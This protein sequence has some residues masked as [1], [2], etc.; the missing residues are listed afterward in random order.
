M[1]GPTN[2][3]ANRGPSA[4]RA[5]TAILTI[6]NLISSVRILAIPAFVALIVNDDTASAGIVLFAVVAATDWI[7]GAVA[8]RTGQVSQ[9][10]TILDPVADRLA[11]AAGLV[12]LVVAGAVPLWV[13]LVVVVRDAVVLLVGALALGLRGIRVEVRSLGKIATFGLMVSITG[14]AWGHFDVPLAASATAL[15]WLVFPVALVEYY[16]ATAMYAGDLRRALDAGR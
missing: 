8:R 9:L 15:G 10:G 2:E 11:I 14:I 7:D 12:A 13:A 6:P 3:P 1:D 4:Q 16:V 5:S